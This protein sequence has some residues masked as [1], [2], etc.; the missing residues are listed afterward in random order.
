MNEQQMNEEPP[1]K[2]RGRKPKSLEQ[3]GELEALPQ[4]L[5]DYPTERVWVSLGATI[6]TGDYENQKIDMGISGVPVGASQEYIDEL[7]KAA[8]MTSQQVIGAMA[9]EMGRI[10]KENYGR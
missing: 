6:K 1:L 8:I 4:S 2:R 9:E 10:L 3:S 5:L 7:M